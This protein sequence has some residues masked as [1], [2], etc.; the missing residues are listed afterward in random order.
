MEPLLESIRELLGYRPFRCRLCPGVFYASASSPAALAHFAALHPTVGSVQLLPYFQPELDQRVRELLEERWAREETSEESVREPA[1]QLPADPATF[2][3]SETP[4]GTEHENLSKEDT[5]SSSIGESDASADRCQ[6]D[7][8]D[9]QIKREYAKP[10]SVKPEA[11]EDIEKAATISKD[12]VRLDSDSD[13]E[14]PHTQA[15]SSVK[16]CEPPHRSK[17]MQAEPVP[18]TAEKPKNHGDAKLGETPTFDGKSPTTYTCMLCEKSF[19]CKMRNDLRKN[20]LAHVT[21][22]HLNQPLWSCTLCSYTANDYGGKNIE[23]H[24]ARHGLPRTEGKHHRRSLRGP[25]EAAIKKLFDAAFTKSAPVSEHAPTGPV[26]RSLMEEDTLAVLQERPVTPEERLSL[27]DIHFEEDEDRTLYEGPPELTATDPVMGA[28]DPAEPT[29]APASAVEGAA[30]AITA[31]AQPASKPTDDCALCGARLK[32]A[33]YQRNNQ[34]EHV[35]CRHLDE[36]LWRCLL[37]PFT[38][39]S[40][41]A[42]NIRS[43]VVSRHGV[44]VSA[45]KASVRR[46]QT[47][48]ETLE[49]IRHK[50]FGE[51]TSGRRR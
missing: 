1:K 9:L 28:L 18:T 42:G 32:R 34:L 39:R 2:R 17:P 14:E 25:W 5:A 6:P 33:V 7:Q 26:E 44:E 35:A 36:A 20:Q 21:R 15:D 48:A 27:A 45:V 23:F 46:Q 4:L 13:E 50:A 11:S 24:M 8:D 16:Q 29:V 31:G 30:S 12:T 3:T 40:Y 49:T 22:V 19:T 43:H 51:I 10:V 47:L 37:C 38:S 41:S